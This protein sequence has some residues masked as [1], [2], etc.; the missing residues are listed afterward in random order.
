MKN[1]VVLGL[2]VLSI[3]GCEPSGS[4]NFAVPINTQRKLDTW[5]D[6]NEDCSSRGQTVLRLTAL[7]SHGK[8][9]FRYGEDYPYYEK[10]NVRVICN[11]K[12]VEGTMVWYNP[13][14]G[15]AG[16]DSLSISVLFPSGDS[17][18]MTY[19]ITVR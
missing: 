18:D 5:T 19:S 4:R 13:D 3:A 8:V 9:E 1:A 15:Y 12:S 2:I 17:R 6:L 14:A 11:K 7:P 16:A 10:D